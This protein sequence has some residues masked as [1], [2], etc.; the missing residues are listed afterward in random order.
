MK[1]KA[2]CSK[3]FLLLRSI[4]KSHLEWL[5]ENA[6]ELKKSSQRTLFE[7]MLEYLN[8]D[9]E[10]SHNIAFTKIFGKPYNKSKDYL[11]R[12]EYRLL[13]QWIKKTLSKKFVDEAVKEHSFLKYLLTNNLYDIFEEEYHL[14]WK[15][16]V[17]SDDIDLLLQLSD[18]NIQFHI[19]GKTQSLATAEEVRHLSIERINL[20]KKFFLREIRKEE[21]R[22]RLAERIISAYKPEYAPH[23]SLDNIDLIEIENNDPQAH[24]ISRKVAINA[25]HGLE[26]IKRIE[27]LL[28]DTSLIKKYERNYE[29]AIFRFL[30]NIAIEYYVMNKLQEALDSFK[31]AEEYIK[32]AT[33]DLL[34][35]FVFNYCMLLV[36][37]SLFEIARNTAYKYKNIL[38]ENPV[39][40]SRGYFLICILELYAGNHEAAE[41]YILLETKKEGTEFYYLMRIALSAAYYLRGDIELAIRETINLEQAIHYELSK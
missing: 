5:K 11:L 30:A 4:P 23:P 12:N 13:Y 37:C 41:N 20:L 16:A 40:R 28:E 29:E 1:E 9:D 18:L 27:A 21:S 39:I 32:Y 10:P 26:K 14:E 22:L 24:Y 19:N 2:R 3:L 25:A 36:R 35:P 31:K 34:P 17:K 15:E 8:N 33:S 7:L 38:M 6:L